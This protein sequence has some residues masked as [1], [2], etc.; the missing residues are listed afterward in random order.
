MT[1]K[2]IANVVLWSRKSY[3]GV[4]NSVRIT[5]IRD[6]KV[7]FS[8]M[9]YGNSTISYI[10]NAHEVMLKHGWIPKK[11]KE[12]LHLYERENNYP[13]IWDVFAGTEKEC[14]ENGKQ[15]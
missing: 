10:Q 15:S 9:Q 2:F 13:T 11:Y 3:G 4:Y 12:F 5:R 1:K 6:K 14:I 7:I 8:P